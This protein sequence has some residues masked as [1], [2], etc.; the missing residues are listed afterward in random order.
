[1]YLLLLTEQS[2][3]FWLL[4]N[5]YIA[6]T[7]LFRLHCYYNPPSPGLI[8]QHTNMIHNITPSTVGHALEI[9]MEINEKV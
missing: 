2:S 3:I 1:M 4:I 6:A 5:S 7:Q 8:N 9:Y